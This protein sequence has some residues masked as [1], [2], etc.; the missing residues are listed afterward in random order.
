MKLT[1]MIEGSASALAEILAN[2]DGVP[3]TLT[4]V[5]EPLQPA[6]TMPTAPVTTFQLS[7]ATSPAEMLAA[8]A[9]QMPPVIA[10]APAPQAVSELDKRGVPH[11]PEVHA[12]NKATNNDGSWRKKR[13]VDDA[14]VQAAE[15]PYLNGSGA[16]QQMP[17]MPIVPQTMPPVAIP[18]MPVQMP[19]PVPTPAPA[20]AAPAPTGALDFAGFMGHI[21]PKLGQTIDSEYLMTVISRVNAAFAPFGK[22]IHAITDVGA[23]QQ[24]L[25]YTVQIMQMDGRW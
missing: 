25:D 19:E 18:A 20:P 21:G 15:A 3:V 1:L 4:A 12:G 7:A 5:E 8:P 22:Q 13:G 11:N 14:I 16:A 10:P 23:D 6:P 2:L 9:P 17:P 24:I